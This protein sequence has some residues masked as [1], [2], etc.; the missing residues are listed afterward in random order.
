[1]S[2]TR[3]DESSMKT[4]HCLL[5]RAMIDI[6]HEGRER[7]CSAVFGLADLFH[8]IPLELQRAAIGDVDY[9]TVLEMLRV[10]AREKNCEKW[11]TDQLASLSEGVGPKEGPKEHGTEVRA[12]RS[13]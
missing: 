11:L 2:D 1:M 12:N 7:K 8:S 5:Y 6:R 3:A 13:K 10:S 9:D 4:I